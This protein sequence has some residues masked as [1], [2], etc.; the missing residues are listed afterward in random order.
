MLYNNAGGDIRNW[1]CVAVIN[2][3]QIHKPQKSHQPLVTLCR[4]LFSAKR[5][6]PQWNRTVVHYICFAF[7]SQAAGDQA[8]V[9]SFLSD[10]FYNLF[11]GWEHLKVIFL[12][13]LKTYIYIYI[14]DMIWNNPCKSMFWRNLI[15]HVFTCCEISV[16]NWVAIPREDKGLDLEQKNICIF[17]YINSFW[18]FLFWKKYRQWG[19]FWCT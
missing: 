5:S 13:A 15:S 1:F 19:G 11:I 8:C 2:G 4:L 16:C 9:S 7:E 6:K 10:G 18:E 12:V 3:A 17:I 14:S